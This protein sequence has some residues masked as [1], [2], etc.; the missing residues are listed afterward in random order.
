MVAM[1]STARKEIPVWAI[2]AF[3]VLGAL[4]VFGVFRD[5]RI[6]VDGCTYACHARDL[7]AGE[8]SQAY[9]WSHVLHVPVLALVCRLVGTQAPNE[10]LVIYQWLDIICGA[11]GLGLI[12]S[13]C[14]RLTASRLASFCACLLVMFSWV[15]WIESVSADEK[16]LGFVFIPLYLVLLFRYMEDAGDVRARTVFR[17]TVGLSITLTAAILLHAS[18]VL[19]VPV[20]L[21][22]GL[23][24]RQYR[25]VVSVASMSLLM[26]VSAYMLFA[27]LQGASS[28]S[29]FLHFFST[30]TS[31]YSIFTSY[32]V[33]PHLLLD[34]AQ[35][36]TKLVW[37]VFA[38]GDPRLRI[39]IAV[40]N[41]LFL[42]YLVLWTWRRRSSTRYRAL[43]VLIVTGLIFGMTY[44][45]D[46]PDSYFMLIIPLGMA[47]AG[48]LSGSRRRAGLLLILV[49][50][51]INNS[52]H[53]YSFS[54][55]RAERTELAY[56]MAIEEGL[57][58]TATLIYLDNLAS[59]E[60][61][62]LTVFSIHSCFQEGRDL[63]PFTEFS[64]NPLHADFRE[65]SGTGNLFIEGICFENSENI[66]SCDVSGSARY[67]DLI[68]LYDLEGAVPFCDYSSRY[69]R[70]YKNVYRLTGRGLPA[71]RTP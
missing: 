1:P 27:R 57:P 65:V 44:A 11:I 68:R 19:V 4:I 6:S 10:I 12:F 33:S 62:T 42:A 67:Q 59:I 49:A 48:A 25:L 2:Q 32:P 7:L 43:L 38:D 66:A 51:M 45:P 35:G 3:I 63:V 18:A 39:A 21:Y 29:E 8:G 71:A 28:A 55:F 53:Y 5:V 34:Y 40:A 64:R 26:T 46:S 15:Y 70:A 58:D 9:V 30:G 23:S 13:L 17:R 47:Y 22:L 14:F 50:M 16:M 54:P 36:V 41:A 69:H 56:E 24:R 31:T 60:H 37:A 20:S 61:R 52:W